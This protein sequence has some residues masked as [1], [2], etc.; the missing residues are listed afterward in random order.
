M[1][2]GRSNDFSRGNLHYSWKEAEY[3]YTSIDEMALI[4]LPADINYILEKTGAS[5]LQLLTHSQGG[6][7]A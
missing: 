2:N 3:W 6:M 4:D 7:C 1:F 5:K